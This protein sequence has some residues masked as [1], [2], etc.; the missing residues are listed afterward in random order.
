MFVKGSHLS[1][2]RDLNKN[3]SLTSESTISAIARYLSDF[4]HSFS[5]CLEIAAGELANQ[6]NK[7]MKSPD[8]YILA[9]LLWFDLIANSLLSQDVLALHQWFPIGEGG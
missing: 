2:M 5:V 8:L 3:F 1:A 9:E 7:S 4:C 6:T